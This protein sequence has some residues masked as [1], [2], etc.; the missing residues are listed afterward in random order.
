[1]RKPV[2]VA[3]RA[4]SFRM[5]ALAT[6]LVSACSDTPTEP[7]SRPVPEAQP[8]ALYSVTPPF[9]SCADGVLPGGALSRICFPPDWNGDA[10]IWAHGYRSPYDPVA[11]PDDEIGG[12]SVQNIVLGLRYAYATTS[13]RRNGLVAVDAATDLAQVSDALGAAAA[14]S[15]RFTFVVGASAGGHA[16]ALALEGASPHF[17]GGLVACA[18][19]GW[20]RGQINYFGDARALFDYFFPGVLPGEAT[21]IPAAV[22]SNWNSVY[23][24]AVRA[25]LV[26]SPSK[27]AQLIA[28]GGI[29]VD[30]T[31][32]S[33]AIESIVDAIWYNVFATNDAR[34]QL[35]GNPFD[36][37]LRWYSGSSNDFRLNLQIRRYRADASA[38]NAMNP[39][40]TTGRLA[41]P[42]QQLHTRYDPVIPYWQSQLY[43]TK[44]FL[45]SGIQLFS[46]TSENYGHCAFSTDEVLA[47]FAVLVL[48]VSFRNLIAPASVFPDEASAARFLDLAREGGAQPQVWSDERIREA[49]LSS[50][51]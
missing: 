18:P 25:A 32:P 6:V 43:Q 2:V 38:L 23:E 8:V 28:T 40:E 7:A 30:P 15:L 51:R 17:S 31:D 11:I 42:A 26:A 16:T 5:A 44:A 22:I 12:Q 41:R 1:M 36:N 19:A 24:P 34:S 37:R 35:G 46:A 13:F 9:V 33:S 20:F 27:T 10:V 49:V 50:S 4:R 29:A 21:S 14:G 48:R 47:S 3:G 39:Y 45:R